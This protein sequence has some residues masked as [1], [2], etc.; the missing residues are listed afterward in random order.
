[1]AQQYPAPDEIRCTKAVWGYEGVEREF[2]LLPAETY[3]LM[4]YGRVRPATATHAEYIRALR[5]APQ[6]DRANG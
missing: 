5:G 3:D 2:G 1:M 4:I 6:E